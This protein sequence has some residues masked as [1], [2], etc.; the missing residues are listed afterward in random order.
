MAIL[1]LGRLALLVGL[2]MHSFSPSLPILQAQMPEEEEL[3]RGLI[4]TYTA[5][6]TI[7][8]LEP[9]V[10]LS[11]KSGEAPHP[12]LDATEGKY[13]WQGYLNLLTKGKYRFTAH[14]RGGVIVKV[15]DQ[16]VLEG[17]NQEAVRLLAGPEVELSAGVLPFRVEYT[18]P[19]GVARLELFWQ[20][21]GF[22]REPL[23]AD[24]L[25]YVPGKGVTPVQTQ[26]QEDRGRYL[27]EEHGCVRC[28]SVPD[29]NK[30]AAQLDAR[31]GPDLSKVGGRVHAGWIEKW[32]ESPQALQPSA[33]MPAVFRPD[34]TGKAERHAVAVYL[35]SLGGKIPESKALPEKE[36][37][38]R[39]A[40]GE[41]LYHSLGCVTCH[42]TYHGTAK[43]EVAPAGPFHG[44]VTQYP[45]LGLGSKTTPEKLVEFLNNPLAVNPAGRMPHMLLTGDEAR[46]LAWYL[47]GK[48]VPGLAAT[49]APPPPAAALQ[50]AFQRV[51]PREDELAEWKKLPPEQQLLE[52]G[53]RAVI[54]HGCNN[55][56]KIE[57]DNKPFASVRFSDMADFLTPEK[58]Q[59]GCL[60]EA[61][62]ERSPRFGLTPPQ[63]QAIRAFLTT[64]LRGAGSPAPNYQARVSLQRFN[65][66]ACHQRDGEGGLSPSLIENLRLYE[67]VEQAEA[68]VPPPLTGVGHKLRTSALKGVLTQAVR[69]RPYM[70]LRMPQFGEANVGHLVEGLA[71]LEGS[72]PDDTQH[73]VELTSAKLDSGRSLAGKGAFG[74][75]SCHDMAGVPN[76]GTRGPDLALTPQRVRYDWYLRWLEQPQRMQPGTRMP[77]VFTNGKSLADHILGGDAEAQAEAMWAYFSLGSNMPLPEGMEPP[78]GLLVTVQDRPVLLRTF[79]PEAGSRAIA[80]GYPGGVSLAYD[81]QTARLAYAWTGNFVDATP[82][83]GNRGGSPI[84]VLG[85]RLWTS[86]AGC[87]VGLTEG[88][89]PP[90]FA[91]RAKE[92]AYGANPP[93]GGAYLGQSLLRFRGYTTDSSGTPTFRYDIDGAGATVS[94]AER[95]QA[96]RAPAG[97]GIRRTFTL[98]GPKDRTS[99]LLL[100]ECSTEPQQVEASGQ[101]KQLTLTAEKGEIAVDA[102]ALLLPVSAER[103]QMIRVA[104]PGA[105]YRIQK[106]G[107]TWQVLVQIPG[108]GVP[109]SVDV[110]IWHPYRNEA[111]L[112]R[113]LLAGK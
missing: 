36:L 81:A 58:L 13:T 93:D 24:V 17:N 57:P 14:L 86:P 95:I 16:V 50:A 108:A 25:S 9:G 79:M 52:L 7:T 78:K 61:A 5:G 89:D 49:L 69:V 20:G 32:L 83:W 12:R 29:G 106:L 30:V 73:R 82:V 110:Q 35:A 104:A 91:S 45:L 101:L 71:T 76:L 39:Q 68:L 22:R 51:D 2:L 97:V 43:I 6:E 55:C 21:P 64:G 74:C 33:V 19:A 105:K 15:G 40:R 18:R 66:L 63:R 111:T 1:R 3:A 41:K 70:G 48:T 98:D 107:A 84:K 44:E 54:A 102:G 67:K 42:G 28:H 56:H 85:P 38:T 47:T 10:A 92:P 31:P 4:A 53:K 65:C 60:A 75:A 103:V 37:A 100:A 96:Q 94:V 59:A 8:T 77:A 23:T 99:W 27:I 26:A 90:D 80:I 88:N 34:E 11:L 62:S 112:L 72:A 113:E 46:D 109:R 87:P